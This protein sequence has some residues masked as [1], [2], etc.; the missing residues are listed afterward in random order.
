MT[1]A[2]I[3]S[4]LHV[5]DPAILKYN[6]LEGNALLNRR[7]NEIDFQE[8]SKDCGVTRAVFVQCDCEPGQSIKEAQWVAFL[9]AKGLPVQGIVAHA[10][11]ELGENVR[12]HLVE[13]SRIPLLRG[14]RRLIQSEN[15]KGFCLQPAFIA[16]VQILADY[17]F[18]FDICVRRDQLADAILLARACPKVK[19]ILDHCGNPDILNKRLEPW[20]AQISELSQLKNV[21]CKLSGL[22]TVADEKNWKTEDLLPYTEHVIKCF[23]VEKVL[24]GGDWPVVLKTSTY[25]QWV[26]TVQA[27]LTNY[28]IAERQKIFHDNA[29][30]FYGLPKK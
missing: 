14:V 9:V 19:F 3:D 15:S 2:I 5:W 29:V 20:S 24:F 13:L 30:N 1:E 12:P 26:N 25:K 27:L 16:G 21:W 18:S 23:G 28:T 10:P 4:H 8:A 11:V 6:W 7:Y 17:D 22:T